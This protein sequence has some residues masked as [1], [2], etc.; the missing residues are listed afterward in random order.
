[1]RVAFPPRSTWVNNCKGE[2]G[3]NLFA[4]NGGG[5]GVSVRNFL[6]LTTSCADQAPKFALIGWLA[7]ITLL[8]FNLSNV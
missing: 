5:E 1:M 3:L 7:G 8:S 4:R 2:E 6:V